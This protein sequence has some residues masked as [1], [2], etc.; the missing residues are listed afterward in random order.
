MVFFI[1]L[2]PKDGPKCGFRN[3]VH[4]LLAEQ[5]F[6]VFNSPDPYCKVDTSTKTAIDVKK[7]ITP[8]VINERTSWAYFR[9]LLES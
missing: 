2:Q 6:T 4:A 3:S 5:G 1:D 9:K 7:A 8:P